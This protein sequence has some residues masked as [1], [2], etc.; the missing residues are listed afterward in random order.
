M[1]DIH[2]ENPIINNLDS[3]IYSS[4]TGD[5]ISNQTSNTT[6]DEFDKFNLYY[7][8]INKIIKRQSKLETALIL[9]EKKLE[10]F[11]KRLKE[12][13]NRN[14]EVIGLFS[15]VLALLIA[16]VN[17][18]ST[19][20]SFLSAILLCVSLT[21]TVSI[22]CILIHSFFN[23]SNDNKINKSFWIPISL[24]IIMIIIGIIFE[25]ESYNLN[26]MS[27][28]KQPAISRI[29]NINNT[30]QKVNAIKMPVKK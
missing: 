13:S 25:A 27:S 22:F 11:S 5:T 8:Q 29:E 1:E 2:I 24:L 23:N 3:S 20:T 10:D 21:C 4:P 18:I 17:I 12:N 28:V 9:D 7:R 15:S 16:H 19:S 6:G 26:S 14:I 30:A